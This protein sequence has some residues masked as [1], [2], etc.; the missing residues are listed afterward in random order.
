M[1]RNKSQFLMA[2]MEQ[3]YGT[4]AAPTGINAIRVRDPKLTTLDPTV[5]ARPSLD[6]QFGMAL[7]D[8]M[9]ELKNGVA[10][11]VEAVGSG[12]AGT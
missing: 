6:G 9:T 12:A 7:S 4:S 5:V 8:V 11:D 2:A 10:F 3:T 1:A